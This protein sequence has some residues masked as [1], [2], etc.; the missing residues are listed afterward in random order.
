MRK[1]SLFLILALA[2]A[3]VA[4]QDEV[5]FRFGGDAYLAGRSVTLTENGT[6]DVF[7]A[8][9]SV[10]SRGDVAGSAHMAGRS[11]TFAGPISGNVYGAGM[12]VVLDASVGGNATLM[13]YDISVTEPVEGNLRAT[14]ARVSVTAPVNGSALLAGETVEVGAQIAGDL[15]IAADFVDWDE[16]ARV[17]GD[18]QIYTDKPENFTVP[19]SVA[20]ADRVTFHDVA[21]FERSF[22]VEK[23]SW[24]EKA[25][26]SFGDRVSDFIRGVVVVGLL[27]TLL[28]AIAPNW[29]AGLRRDALSEPLRTL[30]FGF[31]GVSA[32]IGSVVLLVMTGF[33]IIVAPFAL[34]AAGLLALVGYIVGAYAT[35]VF[36]L[37]AFGR[38][39][40]DSMADRALAA[41]T[42]AFV[43]AVIAIAPFLG[44][45]VAL[46]VALTGAGALL[47]KWFSPGFYHDA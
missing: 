23:G 9:E 5:D 16:G 46:A 2:A 40:P 42:G 12:D 15:A 10:S 20:D 33:G 28:A 6:G 11:V 24:I 39:L 34:L 32:L 13:G 31:L 47:I 35:G 18:V 30:W 17:L 21:K 41:F 25:R 7:A 8:G 45:L 19:A 29:V 44:W 1:F 38:D 26:P 43:L 4:A 22:D 27:A 3:P 36:A 14:G 37:S